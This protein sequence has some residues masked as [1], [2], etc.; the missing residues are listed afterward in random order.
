MLRL[1]DAHLQGEC[2]CQYAIGYRGV[3]KKR[4][5]V[6]DIHVCRGRPRSGSCS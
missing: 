4:L 5:S 3:R 1:D 6:G 2:E